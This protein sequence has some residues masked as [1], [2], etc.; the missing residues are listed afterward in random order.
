V[1]LLPK[2]HC[3]NCSGELKIIAGILEQPVIAKISRT[4][5]SRRTLR[6]ARLPWPS[7]ASGLTLANP[8][9]FRRPGDQG[10]WSR[11]L[12]YSQSTRLPDQS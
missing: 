4:W 2:E 10:R 8:L 5:D 9:S 11:L 6:S 7:A 3:L 12:S 1:N